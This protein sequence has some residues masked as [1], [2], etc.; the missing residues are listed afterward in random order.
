MKKY[1]KY[2]L[3][4]FTFC[5][6]VPVYAYNDDKINTLAHSF[7]G[8]NQVPGL[9]MAVI[10][11]NKIHFY[12]L[13][14]ADP[15]KKI[16]TSNQT[17]YTIGSFSKTFT[18][19]LAARAMVEKKLNLNDAFINYFPELKNNTNLNKITFNELLAHVSGL[20][21]DFQP[22]PKNYAELIQELQQYKPPRTPGSEYSYSN[23]GIGLVGYVL[24][25]IY[26]QNYQTVLTAK[27]LVPLN[28]NSTYLQVPTAKEKYL[29]VGHDPKNNIV[30]YNKN[31]ETWFAAASLKSNISDLAKYLYAQINTDTL[32][33]KN[34]SKAI[35]LAHQTRYCFADKLSCEQLSWQ[36]HIISDLKSSTGDT[37]FINF[38]NEGFPLFHNKKIINGDPLTNSK[39]FIDK[40]GSGY[41]MSSYMVYIPEQKIGVV[42]L[43]NK[44]L[45][46]ERI[47]LGRD[48]L[49]SIN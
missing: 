24:Q 46:D 12:N 14:W 30:A 43:T 34:L 41:G 47:K 28:M 4:L 17:I 7:M 2:V 31:I 29:A 6:K 33:D 44:F 11:H 3:F 39:I 20:P 49:Q 8:K 13:G 37:Y 45:G 35:T 16:P 42:I 38:D 40:T 15:I 48:I 27:V 5:L 22:R 32:R 9:S 19:T 21:F 25:S 26:H 18:A 10:D 1:F 23:A 36:A